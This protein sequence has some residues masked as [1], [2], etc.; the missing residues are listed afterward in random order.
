MPRLNV[1]KMPGR[2]WG[3]MPQGK[4]LKRRPGLKEGN[5]TLRDIFFGF[6]RGVDFPKPKPQPNVKGIYRARESKSKMS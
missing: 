3:K 6:E 2:I 1:Q 5:H 4:G